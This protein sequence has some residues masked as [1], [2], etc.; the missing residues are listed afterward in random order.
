MLDTS[1]LPLSYRQQQSL[2]FII[3]S[4]LP[5]LTNYSLYLNVKYQVILLSEFYCL[6]NLYSKY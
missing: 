2:I 5:L 6:E 4:P 1:L 3:Y